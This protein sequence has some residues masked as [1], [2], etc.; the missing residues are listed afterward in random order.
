MKKEG[1][2]E[3]FNPDL[4]N[5]NLIFYIV[6]WKFLCEVEN[7]LIYSFCVNFAWIS[8]ADDAHTCAD[9][10]IPMNFEQTSRLHIA[11]QSSYSNNDK[12]KHWFWFKFILY[13]RMHFTLWC[14][15][16]KFFNFKSN[17]KQCCFQIFA[18]PIATRLYCSAEFLIIENFL[19]IKNKIFNIRFNLVQSQFFL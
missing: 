7:L 17:S 2:W 12:E 4:L 6:S 18:N 15:I 1:N 10:K 3:T 13:R 16:S 8:S 19:K 14:R 11:Q 9:V 5:L